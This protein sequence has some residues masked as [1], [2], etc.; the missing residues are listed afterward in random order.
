MSGNDTVDMVETR[1]ASRTQETTMESL[2][3][4]IEDL[5]RR[6]EQ[7]QNDMTR[8][9]S[10]EGTSNGPHVHNARNGGVVANQ[11]GRMSKI[12]FPRF[13][14][15]DVKSWLFR[16]R[17]FF[18]IDDVPENMK[19]EL[20]A[21]HLSD[22]ALVW[23]QQFLKNY[24]DGCDWD[25]YAEQALK[26]FGNVFEDPMVELKNLK[27]TS[28]V[29]VYQDKFE[30]L[31]NRM[32]L[33][34]SLAM[35]L[36]IG[37]LKDEISMPVRMFKPLSLADLFSMAKMQEATL[38]ATKS[39]YNSYPSN[40]RSGYANRDDGVLPRPVNRPMNLPATTRNPIG[41]ENKT[42]FKRLT[43]KELEDKRAKNICFYCDKKYVPGHK[44][45]GQLHSLEVI[46]DEDYEDVDPNLISDD[47][48][49]MEDYGLAAEF[50]HSTEM[51]P[52]ISL[53]ALTGVY[54]YQTMRVKGLVRRQGVHVLVDC[55]STHNF[56]DLQTVK[57]LGC[58]TKTMCPLQV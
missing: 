57:K 51:V 50:D 24:G 11:Y 3:H 33:T 16:C 35:S 45:S 43:Q 29:Q 20:A 41:G 25:V 39:R 4:T 8:M 21:M 27:Q 38:L 34:E 13:N 32:N 2:Q 26:R 54:N 1:N 52:Q 15:D 37:G 14:G 5:L 58:K 6:M 17:H 42:G 40:V 7:M 56:I 53:N 23:H 19:V 36:F 10:G 30:D 46:V 44:C 48:G 31:L 22:R 55:G 9:R 49:Q 12:E 18:R 28:T 47:M